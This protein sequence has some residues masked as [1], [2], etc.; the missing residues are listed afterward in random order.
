MENFDDVINSLN[1]DV[2]NSI[3]SQ[4]SEKDKK[5]LLMLQRCVRESSDYVYLEIGSHLGGTIQPHY[6]DPRCNQIFSIDKRPLSQPDERGQF[7]EYPENTTERMLDNL[8]LAF[9]SIN[10]QK[11]ITFDCDAR[12]I[13][14]D[15]IKIKPNIC[16]IDGE[17]T[18][19]AAFS[20]FLFCL[21]V[22][23]RDAIIVLHD[24]NVISQG[25]K[26]IKKYLSDKSITFQGILLND[27]IYT[28]LLNGGINKYSGV[29][30]LFLKNEDTYFRNAQRRIIITR[31]MNRYPVLR[32]IYKLIFDMI[33]QLL[34]D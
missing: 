23:Q 13:N 30:K 20:D 17:H 18:N 34:M 2:F 8:K 1:I 29:L 12:E 9:P 15:E 28:F 4:T 22:C 19:V 26:N 10:N 14:I 31:L 27:S 11:I 25:I 33:H 7:F 21:K 6:V 5:S 16:F 32:S 24:A 3:Q